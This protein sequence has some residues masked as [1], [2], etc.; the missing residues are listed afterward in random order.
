M[1]L[2][3]ASAVISSVLTPWAPSWEKSVLGLIRIVLVFLIGHTLNFGIN[4]LGS[5][6]H[7]SRL[8]YVEFFAS[9]LRA[10]AGPSIRKSQDKISLPTTNEEEK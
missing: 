9:S 4:I 1:A 5:Y 2:G 6:V 3:I 8:Q 10:A 7:S